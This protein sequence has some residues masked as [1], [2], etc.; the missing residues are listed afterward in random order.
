ML[1][2]FDRSLTVIQGPP[3]TGKTFIGA[4]ICKIL[5]DIQMARERNSYRRDRNP[6][7]LV[8]YTNHALDQFL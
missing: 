3:G 7:Y 1:S 2:C 4:N 5:L 8:C 6:I